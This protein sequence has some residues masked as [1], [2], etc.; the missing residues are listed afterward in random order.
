MNHLQQLIKKISIKSSTK[1]LMVV[2]DGL[3]GV[4]SP[5]TGKSELESASIP[6]LDALARKSH[7]GLI[8]PVERGI[9]PGSGPAH[10]SLFG[11]DPVE[12]DIGRGVLEALGIGF[13]LEKDDLACRAN[14]ATWDGNVI[15]DR[16]AGRIPTEKNR[17]LCSLLQENITEIENIQV[18]IRPG[19]GHRFVVI[20]RGRGLHANLTE[21]DPQK[22]GHSPIA[23]KARD[24]ESEFS[25]AIINKFILKFL[26]VEKKNPEEFSPANY[27]LM[28]GFSHCPDI[29]SMEEIYKLNSAAIATYPMYRGLAQLVGMD[30]LSCKGES[31]E[32][33]ISTLKEQYDKFDFFYFHIKETDA[34]GEDGNFKGKVQSLEKIDRYV[35]QLV[36]MKPDVLIITGDHSTPSVLKSHSWHPVPIL[37]YSKFMP[38]HA[39]NG[40]SEKECLHG[41]LGI[42]HSSEIMSI[43]MAN[44][45]KLAKYGA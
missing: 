43:A 37:I 29:P 41:S 18:I 6:N 25:G 27:V 14:F 19:K 31:I 45:L 10:L 30:I 16:R 1:I 9:T 35:P 2:L 36:D 20:F 5:E 33:E 15:T 7:C 11:Y 12:Y 23:I 44:A 40:F 24:K 28:R 32:D 3:G 34:L 8:I 42:F 39:V 4:L 38:S 22:E 21:N 26:D 17:K 13:P